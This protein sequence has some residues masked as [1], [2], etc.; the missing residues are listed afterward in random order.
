MKAIIVEKP[1]DVNVLK[2]KEVPKPEPG[3]HDLL[4]EVH[5]SALNR[6][7]IIQRQAI[8]TPAAHASH[9]L[10]I[11]T[12]GIVASC[13]NEVTQF[14][15]GDSVFGFVNGGAYAEYCL[16]DE[17]MA[18]PLPKNWEFAYAAAIPEVF[19][20]ASERLFTNGD[21]QKGQTVLIHAGASGV[22]TAAIQLA[23]YAGA[24]VII[25]AGS[26]DKIN[27][28]LALGAD[29]GINYKT[30]DFVVRV[31]QETKQEG[32]D[33]IL[34]SIGPDYLLR[35]QAAL[36]YDGKLILMGLLS[37]SRGEIDIKGLIYKRL[38]IIG[39]NLTRRSL[40]S[41]R[42]VCQRFLQT[43]MPILIKGDI[44]PI[45]DSIYPLADA[46]KAHQRMEDNL[47]FGK[48]LLQV[49]K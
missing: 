12:A 24:K 3:P 8:F 48:I 30:E 5:A 29:I 37:G 14:K 32:V 44:K 10:G 16:M 25:T 41:Q 15:I 9:I 17:F 39:N 4:I 45:I 19:I 2:L 36:K 21:L 22:G 46:K 7:D 40:N 42:E 20:T 27:K 33:L 18:F 38:S 31:L 35:N 47:N 28:C 26:K 43:W 11:E 6:L 34:D 13:G 1:G 49:R 23:K